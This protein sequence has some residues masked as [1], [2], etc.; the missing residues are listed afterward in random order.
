MTDA[1]R[2]FVA[3]DLGADARDALSALV[4]GLR[5]AGI[6]A[7]R[8]MRPESIHLTLKFLGDVPR[9][10]LGPIATG[11]SKAVANSRAFALEL[12]GAGVFPNRSR[13]R[14]LWVGVGGDVP[15]LIDLQ[16]EL[17]NAMSGLGFEMDRRPYVPHLTV[18][19]VNDRASARDRR[20]A[21]D[22]LSAAR[23][24]TGQQITV[25][26]VD[27]IQS[28]LGREGAVH[29]RL[30]RFPLSGNLPDDTTK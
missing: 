30:G 7:L 3:I 17:D 11:L 27:L 2:A 13:A 21:A 15:S 8:P 10:A 12:G 6:G 1:V 29:R 20:L 16:S 24:Q 19:R 4:S 26:A 22:A 28:T 18:A 9:A 23:F 5:E 25:T 14:V